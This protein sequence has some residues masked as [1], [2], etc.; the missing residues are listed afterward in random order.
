MSKF[1]VEITLIAVFGF[2]TAVFGEEPAPV[3][4]AP[5][6]DPRSVYEL[7]A[8]E[9]AAFAPTILDGPVLK[10]LAEKEI[11]PAP[12]CSDAVFHR[13]V[14]LDLIGTMPTV[15]ETKTFLADPAPDKRAALVDRLLDRPEFADYWAMK[16]SDALR[17]KAEF[18]INLWPNGAMVYH[19]WIRESFRVNKPINQFA[20]ELLL[21]SGSNFR[22]P[23]ANFYRAS[24]SRNAR[25]I[26]NAVGL[27]FLGARVEDWPIEKQ[28]QFVTLFSRIGFKPS[29]QWKEEI[30]FW[31]DTPLK[32]SE[33]IFP[34]GS[35]G[36]VPEGSDPRVA[37]ADWL[38]EPKNPVFARV[39]VNRAWNWM[40]GS[41]IVQPVDDFRAD[42]PPSQPELLDVLAVEFVRMNYDWKQ[43]L[44]L[45]CNSRTY[46]QS[47]FARSE[48]AE[49][50]AMFAFYPVRQ[51]DAEVLQDMLRQVLVVPLGYFS[52]VPEP[53]TNVPDWRRTI[54]L[55]DASITHPF[56]ETF[57]RPSRDSGMDGDRNLRP[58]VSQRMFLV[59][60]SDMMLWIERSWRLRNAANAVASARK[61][62]NRHKV[63]AEYL[64]LALWSRY[65]TDEEAE[66]IREQF[67]VKGA[68]ETIVFQDILWTMFNSKEFLCRH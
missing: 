17:V 36:T 43:L 27:T 18:P 68:N 10:R 48:H 66:M 13:R 30:V 8:E 12:I 19:R 14:F 32:N 56:L 15:D 28:E 20:R 9:S 39:T 21:G 2:M 33:V 60:S 46:Q 11:V 37:F 62:E 67:S 59:N 41:G 4:P 25:S 50:A 55:A 38:L 63:I 65:P 44:R 26:A 53:Y 42:N 64:F 5:P 16:W 1:I 54:A 58:S 40:L 29:A 61:G 24:Q 6:Q 7:T 47:P 51:I 34:D 35:K 3:E 45:I 49:A 23:P 22:N 52:D 57:G 31:D